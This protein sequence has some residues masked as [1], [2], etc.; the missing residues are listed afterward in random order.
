M[1][2]TEVL[3][4]MSKLFFVI[5]VTLFLFGACIDSDKNAEYNNDVQTT[6]IEGLEEELFLGFSF[7]MSR[8]DMI[9]NAKSLNDKRIIKPGAGSEFIMEDSTMQSLARVAFYPLF[10]ENDELIAVPMTYGYAGWAPWNPHLSADSLAYDLSVMLSDSLSIEF[11]SRENE[12]GSLIYTF[13]TSLPMIKIEPIDNYK[14]SLVY[15]M[16]KQI[17]YSAKHN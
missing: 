5:V 4:P 2:K 17:L 16:N 14:V 7:G 9:S 15:A 1:P 11:T 12:A 13:E 3:I 8:L 6:W 10:N